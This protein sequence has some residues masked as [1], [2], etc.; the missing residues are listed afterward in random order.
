VYGFADGI[1]EH[2]RVTFHWQAFGVLTLAV[3]L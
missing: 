2:Q 3:A 1:G